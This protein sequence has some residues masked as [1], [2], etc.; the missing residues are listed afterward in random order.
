MALQCLGRHAEALGSFSNGLAQDPKSLQLLSGLVEAAMKSPLRGKSSK[1]V[2]FSTVQ[3]A[4]LG[5]FFSVC[6]IVIVVEMSRGIKAQL[7][8]IEKYFDN[9]WMEERVNRERERERE[10]ERCQSAL[11]YNRWRYNRPTVRY[12]QS[13]VFFSQWQM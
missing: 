8:G 7:N 4:G 12:T 9:V 11:Y 5:F 6:P 13:I 3:P 10:R 2:P 1:K